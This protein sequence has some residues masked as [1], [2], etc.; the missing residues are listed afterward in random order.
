MQTR[1]TAN[2]V[3][4]CGFLYFVW[5]SLWRKNFGPVLFGERVSVVPPKS[6]PFCALILRVVHEL[7]SSFQTN[8]V[9]E[10]HSRHF[11]LKYW[12][13]L[14]DEVY[15][16]DTIK[17]I[18]QI[19]MMNPSW[20]HAEFSRQCFFSSCFSEVLFVQLRRCLIIDLSWNL[21]RTELL[22]G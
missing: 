8:R 9:L 20:A 15:I 6:V 7:H 13:L 12:F 11:A 21:S 16:S 17:N 3:N 14:H 4:S 1:R 10:E 18:N 5:S 22:N 2:K 19:W